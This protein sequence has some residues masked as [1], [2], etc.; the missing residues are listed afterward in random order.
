MPL[1]M[2]HIMS[3]KHALILDSSHNRYNYKT[4]VSNHLTLVLVPLPRRQ[5]HTCTN[6]HTQRG[7]ENNHC[8][9]WSL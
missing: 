6:A 5:A 1:W 2:Y 9:D 8:G 7:P 4:H 3:N